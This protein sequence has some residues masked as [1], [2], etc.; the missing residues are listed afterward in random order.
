MNSVLHNK[1]IHNQ[2][3][4]LSLGIHEHKLQTNIIRIKQFFF[5]LTM[6]NY[7]IHENNHFYITKHYQYIEIMTNLHKIKCTIFIEI[8]KIFK[9]N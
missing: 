1:D 3:K 2:K 8:M 4:M 6:G 5:K 9:K 7:L